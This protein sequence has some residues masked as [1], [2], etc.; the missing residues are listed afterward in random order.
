MATMTESCSVCGR[1][2]DVQFRYQ[3]EE[4]DGGFAFYCSQACHGK[5]SESGASCTA[6]SKRFKVELVSQVLQVKGHRAYA[7]S[8]ACRSQLLAEA[9]GVR[10]GAMAGVPSNAQGAA[11]DGELPLVLEPRYA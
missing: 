8:D 11:N 5:S 1:T 9:R 2:F 7:C 10:L 4:Q 6:C 3:M